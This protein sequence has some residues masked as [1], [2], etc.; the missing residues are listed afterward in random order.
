VERDE[1]VLYYQPIIDLHSNA[2]IGVESL[3]RWRHG[4]QGLVSP[5]QFIAA[6][7]EIG[8]GVAF[9]EWVLKRVCS[10]RHAWQKVSGMEQL[11]VSVNLSCSRCRHLLSEA[12]LGRMLKESTLPA[13]H[14]ILEH[15]GVSASTQGAGGWSVAG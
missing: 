11:I 8:V 6:A 4:A 7:E 13:Q 2:L 9:S 12:F 10:Q 3:L 5:R 1:L 14:L 15:P